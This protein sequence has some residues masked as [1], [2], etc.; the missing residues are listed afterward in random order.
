[1]KPFI[2]ITRYPYE[3]PHH[4]NLVMSASNGQL[5][6]KLEFYLNADA[7]AEWATEMEEFPRHARSVVLWELGSERPE[8]RFAFYFR[9][10]LFTT[11]SLGH[12]A[13][14]L[15]F[16]NNAV[17]PEREVSEFCIRSEAA[18]INRLGNLLR[19]Y[20]KLNHQ[21]LDWSLTEGALYESTQDAEQA[22]AG[23]ARN[24]RA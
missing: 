10:R 19:Q 16:N 8:D 4:L 22:A 11:D 24:A 23:D 14:Q 2:R 9:M 12:G 5:V 13:I 21:V 20:S 7:L 18:Q 15:R 1:M 17:L 6:G 3:E